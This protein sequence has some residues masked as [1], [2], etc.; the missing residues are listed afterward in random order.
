MKTIN[1]N[2]PKHHRKRLEGIAQMLREMRFSEG[3]CQDEL[4]EHGITRRQVQRAEYGQL[5][6]RN[7]FLLI[8]FYGY[9]L[10]AFF[11]GME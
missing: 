5:N 7:L 11:K 1:P 10:E 4:I 3:L 8:D 9:T 2:I 6:F